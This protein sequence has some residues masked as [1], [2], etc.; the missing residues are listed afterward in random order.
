MVRVQQVRSP[1]YVH[2]KFTITEGLGGSYPNPV[3]S[4]RCWN[5][6]VFFGSAGCSDIRAEVSF[7]INTDTAVAVGSGVETNPATG[8][9]TS[10]LRV[11][12]AMYSTGASATARRV[13]A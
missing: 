5:G 4:P 9:L 7:A 2:P 6:Q 11:L 3:N 10:T 13:R 8:S 12:A 1:W